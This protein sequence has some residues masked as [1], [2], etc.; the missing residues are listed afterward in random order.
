MSEETEEAEDWEDEDCRKEV[1]KKQERQMAEKL[2]FKQTCSMCP[3]QYDV[4]IGEKQVAYIRLRCGWLA[5]FPDATS[6]TILYE[7]TFSN[8]WKGEFNNEK[9][10]KKYLDIIERKILS[11]L[12]AIK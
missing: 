9:E 11:F 7:H 10:R 8:K 5:V 3:E 6:D 4:F 2:V 1:E 12:E